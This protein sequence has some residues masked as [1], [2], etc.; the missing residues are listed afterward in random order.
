MNWFLLAAIVLTFPAIRTQTASATGNN[1]FPQWSHD[2]AKIAFTSDRDGDPEIYVMNAD[3][4]SPRR[5]T[6]TPGR[7]AHPFFSRDGRKIVFQSPRAN[8]IDTNIYV[9]NSDGS[10]V[11]K[12][13]NLKGFAGVPVYSPDEKLIVFQWRESNNF[14]D[15]SKWRI[16]LMNSDGSG[17]RVI[18]PGQANDQVPNWSRDGK[19]LLFYSDRTGKDQ[20]Y[21]MKP[22][23]TDVLRVVASEF[24]DNAAFWSPDNKKITFASDRDGNTELYVMDADG[25]NPQRLTNTRATERGG[26]WSPDGKRIAFSSD[27][28]GPTRIYTIYADGSNLVCLTEN[29]IQDSKHKSVLLVSLNGDRQVAVIDP[30]TQQALAKLPSPQG[31]HE[32]TLSTDGTHAYISDSG[33][34]PNSRGNSIVILDLRTLSVKTTLKTCESPHDTRIS[35]DGNTLWVACAPAK[36]VLELDVATGAVRKTW[37]TKLEGGWFVEV[38]PDEQK[39]FVPHLEAKAL[40]MIDRRSGEVRTVLSGTTIFGVAV[41]PSGNEVWVSDADEHKLSIVNPAG[42]NVTATVSLGTPKQG[43]FA[44]LRFTPDGKQVVV[45]RGAEF[46]VVDAGRRSIVSRIELPHEGKI[47]TVSGDGRLAFVS[48][49]AADSVSVINLNTRSVER[50]FR[51]GKQPDGV[52]WV[53]NAGASNN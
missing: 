7:D 5:L 9:M 25:K 27:G 47:V 23:G 43:N 28:D 21:T 14:Q 34:G 8:G 10:N 17:F 11:V 19:R 48:H 30:A 20:I 37:D 53:E 42:G 45:V 44:R 52:A 2:G 50:T 51:V 31:P 35:R 24:S 15:D 26:V 18:T 16:C 22:D 32:I 1:M 39:L 33:S 4:S 40:T 46:I 13:T 12:L 41:S 29:A 49:P 6:N 36:A 38:T 3:G